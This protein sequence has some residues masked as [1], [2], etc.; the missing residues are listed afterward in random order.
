MNSGTDNKKPEKVKVKVR[1]ESHSVNFDNFAEQSLARVFRQIYRVLKLKAFFAREDVKKTVMIISVMLAPVVIMSLFLPF[2]LRAIGVV[3]VGFSV[4]ESIARLI[5]YIAMVP[6]ALY[7]TNFMIKFYG[8][9]KSQILKFNNIKFKDVLK[10][11]I[12]LLGYIAISSIVFYLATKLKFIPQ[13]LLRQTQNVGFDKNQSALGLIRVFAVIVIIPPIVEEVLFRGLGFLNL[14]RLVSFWP[15]AIYSSLLF[16]FYHG[17]LNVGLDTFILGLFMAWA[18][19][20]TD[21]LYSSMAIHFVK[22]L[23]A[24]YILF[25]K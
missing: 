12:A 19:E 16:A 5:I 15:A 9:P 10:I 24:F 25:L 20:K 7:I 3:L 21:S 1:D 17:Q 14:R 13:D 6:L 18:V 22:N 11:V 2:I 23:I 8:W 4:P